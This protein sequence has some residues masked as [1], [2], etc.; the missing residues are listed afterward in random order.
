M[1]YCEFCGKQ[2]NDD[3]KCTC[4]DAAQK[5]RKVN[6]ALKFGALI[7]VPL[8]ILIIVIITI[9]SSLRAD[10]SPYLR[11][12]VFSGYN[13]MGTASVAFDE[14]TLIES[15]IGEEP[16]NFLSKEY[17][18]W[19]QKYEAYSAGIQC[20][21]PKEG[22]SNGDTIVI[23]VSVSGE[24]ADKIKNIEKTYTVEGLKETQA[25]DIF[26][27]V[28]VEYSGISGDAQ[29]TIVKTS[30]NEAVQTCRFQIEGTYDLKN[31]DLITVRISNTEELLQNYNVIPTETEKT[32]TVSGL[33]AYAAVTDLPMNEIQRLA[34]RYVTE[35]QAENDA[36]GVESF[37]YS[38]VALYG[39]YFMQEKEDAF[40]ANHNELHILIC[41]DFYIGGEY[42][43][44]NYIPLVFKN[45]VADAEGKVAL[46][47]E[48]GST[49]YFYTDI[50]SYTLKL[51]EKYVVNKIR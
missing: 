33:G 37:S 26:Q 31:G 49:N 35:Q 6:K 28:G 11:E 39:I 9:L 36:E 13:T 1:K 27:Y 50:E 4:D 5:S 25:V 42:D 32:F 7:G 24:P 38:D 18:E 3:E 10:P 45:I 12:P 51:E 29:A 30:E 47:Y 21:Y 2:L 43:R 19:H 15:I 40:M 46:V 34:D 23:K 20:E 17:S 16:A 22:L 44:T 41:Y 14:K 8:L 48:E